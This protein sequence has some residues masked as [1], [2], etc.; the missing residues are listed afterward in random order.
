MSK[1]SRNQAL[2]AAGITGATAGAAWLTSRRTAAQSRE[3]RARSE[4]GRPLALTGADGG[5]RHARVH[6][7][8][9]APTLVL[10]HC[11]TGTQEAWH[12]QVEGLDRE[13]RLVTYDH[14][15]HGLSDN[16][17]DGDY[18]LD[19]LAADL[20]RVIH[21][22]ASDG[23]PVLV[24][25]HSLG[26]MTLVAWAESSRGA[27]TDRVRGAALLSTGLDQLT[28]SHALTRP[29]PGPFATIEGRIAD[30][31]LESP[32]SIRGLPVPIV[33]AAAAF[34]A[35]GPGARAEDIDLT[36]R[37]TLDC[38][39]RARAGCGHAMAR[40]ALLEKLDALD[41]PTIVIAGERDLMTPISHAE[42]IETALPHSLGLRVDPE[43]GHMTP[44]E[45]P[46]LV[47]DALRE[48]AAAT[49]AGAAEGKLA[50]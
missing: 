37:M 42:R 23:E 20:D 27:V 31:F 10:V 14:R 48:V 6:G 26:A 12:K 21:A 32:V 36:A 35:L 39:T 25:G 47:N 28:T 40:M 3:R 34:A 46:E 13:L 44:L 22:A 49:V 30:S 11:W 24:A 19:A 45:S 7:P 4:R 18:S 9:D 43:A 29:L 38:H 8:E 2:V 50:A 41:T 17:K 15:G 16:A 33:R 5:N 1:P